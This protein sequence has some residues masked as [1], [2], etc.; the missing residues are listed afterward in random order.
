MFGCDLER[1]TEVRG[2][3]STRDVAPCGSVC[4]FVGGAPARAQKRRLTDAQDAALRAI[5]RWRWP[6][7]TL[8][9]RLSGSRG[10][11]SDALIAA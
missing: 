1:W 7:E 4:G 10:L 6:H 9:A 3:A 11:D 8:H 5:A 2:D